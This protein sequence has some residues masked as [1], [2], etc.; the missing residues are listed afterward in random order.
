MK[1][2]QLTAILIL[3][4]SVPLLA[5]NNCDIDQML[6]TAERLMDE[7][8]E[9][10][11]LDKYM[12]ILKCDPEN[13]KALWNA[14]LLHSTTGFRYDDEETRKEYFT[15]ALKL[16]QQGVDLYPDSADPRYVVAVAKGRLADVVSTRERIR[17]SHQIEES[18]RKALEFSPEHAPSLHLYGVW[19]SEVANLSRAERFAARF[20]SRGLPEGTN[21]KAE[22]LLK[23]A[24]EQDPDNILIRLDLARHYIRIGDGDRAV[25]Y[26]EDLLEMEPA[27]KDDPDYLEEARELLEG[28]T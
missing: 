14:S 27:T 3:V 5:Q 7:T 12:D 22:E 10:E 28:L 25:P 1:V 26:L 4:L 9:A 13:Y 23:K 11:S 16:A 19:N 24:I 15:E 17:L 8:K 6:E 21:E 20:I 18:V 2:L